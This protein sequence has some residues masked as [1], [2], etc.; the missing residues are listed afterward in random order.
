VPN[1][2]FIAFARCWEV[3]SGGSL[4]KF[5]QSDRVFVSRVPQSTAKLPD[6]PEQN[7]CKAANAIFHQRLILPPILSN[8]VTGPRTLACGPPV[9]GKEKMVALQTNARI[10]NS[11]PRRRG[12]IAEPP[13]M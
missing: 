3:H 13:L 6:N 7:T 4:C 11:N 5:F 1:L 2:Q 9:A 12:I 10:A 8:A